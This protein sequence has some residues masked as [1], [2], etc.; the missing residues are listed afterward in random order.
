MTVPYVL[1][2]G[3]GSAHGDDQAGW[4]AVD[5][6]QALLHQTPATQDH[7][8]ARKLSTPLDLLPL[9]H[10][11]QHVLIVDAVQI[12][13]LEN[14]RGSLRIELPAPWTSQRL[15]SCLAHQ[16]RPRL[17]THGIGLD[18][19][20]QLAQLQ[21]PASLPLVTLFGIPAS[22]FAAFAPPSVETTE[23]A[24]SAAAQILTELEDL[25]PRSLP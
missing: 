13:P 25:V 21:S 8:V 14:L 22:E 15:A 6:L 5:H 10:E 1:V 11:H 2:A 12:P 24:R 23:M 17:D 9:F 18:Q 20:L 7:V 16:P 19:V 4:L 3:L